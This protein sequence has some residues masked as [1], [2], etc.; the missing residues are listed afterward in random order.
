MKKLLGLFACTAL[1]FSCNDQKTAET[2][3]AKTESASTT[4][5]SKDYEIGDS[6][7]VDI[8]KAGLAK[9]ES[10]DIDGWITA[11]ADNAV[12]HWNNYDSLAGKT[13]ITDYWKKRRTDIIDS[14]SFTK[15]I[16]LPVKVNTPLTEGQ[17]TGNYAL[18]WHVT[19]AKYK[20]GKSMKQRVH[21]VYH[22]D[23]NDK[24]D[25]VSQYLDR[26]PIQAAMAK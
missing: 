16:W 9:L 1:L 15:L 17:L 7:Y 24:I 19:Y 10:G 4:P 21:T 22:F 23:A 2:P 11:F 3:E 25:R 12:Y 26:L 5:A 6:K 14:M 20:T 13:A 18:C 8:A